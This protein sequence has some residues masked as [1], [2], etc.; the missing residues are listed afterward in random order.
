MAEESITKQIYTI[1][2]LAHDVFWRDMGSKDSDSIDWN[3][4]LWA[5]QERLRL[6]LNNGVVINKDWCN[7][8]FR[9]PRTLINGMYEYLKGANEFRRRVDV[10]LY[11]GE[12][13]TNAGACD[14][15]SGDVY[16][17]HRPAPDYIDLYF[18][19]RRQIMEA[20]NVLPLVLEKK[21]FKKIISGEK[22]EEYREIKPYW[23]S[24]LVNQQAESGDVLFDEFG[25][26]CRVIGKLEYKPYTHVLFINGY[27]KDSPR[28]EKEI[29]SISIGKPKKGLC[30]DKWLDTEFFI[31]KFK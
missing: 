17:Q 14:F 12:N 30:P 16:Y 5:E 18:Q 24:R 1:E 6:A 20:K 10:V 21:W 31:I 2:D 27:R 4:G 25:G 13:F 22:T 28:I 15:Y 3:K 9:I 26:Y 8:D 19:K 11:Y 29:K 7:E 23:A